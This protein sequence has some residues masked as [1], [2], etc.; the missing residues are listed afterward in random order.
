MGRRD[1][2]YIWL[3]KCVCAFRQGGKRAAVWWIAGSGTVTPLWPPPA[4]CPVM[5]WPKP[6]TIE[7]LW[8][9]SSQYLYHSPLLQPFFFFSLYM[10]CF[11][12]PQPL[13]VFMIYLFS[14]LI[15]SFNNNKKKKKSCMVHCSCIKLPPPRLHPP[16]L[17]DPTSRVFSCLNL[18]TLIP[19]VKMDARAA[20]LLRHG[21]LAMWWMAVITCR[22]N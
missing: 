12:A 19:P 21:H 3:I 14:S 5:S 15:L 20:R 8:K 1:T 2:G 18:P 6:G 10:Y 4:G 17:L 13:R 16:S 7:A 22:R 9:T 11:H